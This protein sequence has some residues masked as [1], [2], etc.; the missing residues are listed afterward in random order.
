MKLR[1]FLEY[2]IS[3]EQTFSGYNRGWQTLFDKRET[4]K[5][6]QAWWVLQE[7]NSELLCREVYSLLSCRSQTDMNGGQSGRDDN[8]K[9]PFSKKKLLLGLESTSD[10]F[11]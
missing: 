4:E 9:I 10:I 1:K 7:L 3:E 11:W 8:F 5:C 2:V 6:E